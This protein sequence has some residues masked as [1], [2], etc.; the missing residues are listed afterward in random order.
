[1]R[2]TAQ[3]AAAGVRHYFTRAPRRTLLRRRLC[4]LSAPLVAL[5]LLSAGYLFWVCA[6]GKDAVGLF[7]RQDIPHLHEKARSLLDWDIL[8]P[9]KAHFAEGDAD[10]LEGRLAAAEQQFTQAVA[11]A[12]N[13][14]SCPARI[15]LVVVLESLADERTNAGGLA[16]ARAHLAKAQGAMREAPAGCFTSKPGG[17]NDADTRI[18]AETAARLGVK[19]AQ[20]AHGDL[21][22]DAHDSAYRYTPGNST[23]KLETPPGP[24]PCPQTDD[25]AQ[26]ACIRDKDQPPP[27]DSPEQQ[28]PSGDG[29]EQPPHED[30]APPENTPPGNAASP[31]DRSGPQ[32][33]PPDPNTAGGSIND[34]GPDRL[35]A[36]GMGPVE[37]KLNPQS[38]ADPA[39]KIKQAQADA[40]GSGEDHE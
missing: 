19:A 17:A 39:A 2:N 12:D 36:P 14:D 18:F 15:N 35:P 11:L 22:Y 24:G 7:D 33:G 40:N 5:A 25:P 8:E 38:G 20:L 32:G 21:R 34:I 1:V 3:Q 30:G 31:R 4:A 28:A 26:T 9:W 29:A 10:V 6:T 13:Q 16:Q 37:H 27:S 23:A